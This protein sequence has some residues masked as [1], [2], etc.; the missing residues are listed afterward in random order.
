M[1]G[2]E[3][4]QTA[5]DRPFRAHQIGIA[6]AVL[7]LLAL[8]VALVRVGAWLAVD[9]AQF[10]EQNLL[11]GPHLLQARG[12]DHLQQRGDQE[13]VGEHGELPDEMAQFGVR[14]LSLAEPAACRGCRG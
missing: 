13:L 8:A 14:G 12:V 11:A 9:H 6:F 3:S 2:P 1:G 10:V 7:V 4:I 5:V